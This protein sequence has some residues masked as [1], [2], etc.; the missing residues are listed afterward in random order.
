M[1]DQLKREIISDEGRV[2]KI[3]MCSANKPTF[4]VGHMITKS[5]PE[6]GL[7]IGTPINP[8]RVDRV[9][10][11]DINNTLTDCR[12][13]YG[14]FDDIP[15]EAQLILANMMFNLGLP[16]LSKFKRLAVAVLRQDWLSAS[17]EMADSKWHK[18]LPN[19]SER[20]ISRMEKLFFNK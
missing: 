1:I 7:E 17:I 15:T 2:A 14:N 20:L 3:Y 18:Q 9:F 10:E 19:R 6:Y 8:D 16:R 5:D 11:K 12:R 13:L 4:G